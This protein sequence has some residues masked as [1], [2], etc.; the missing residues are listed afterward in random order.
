MNRRQFGELGETIAARALE[1]SGLRIVARNVRYPEGEIDIVAED[2]DTL[3]FVEVR[4]RRG[5]A[6]GTPEE[7]VTPR[8]R[9]RLV[10]AAHRFLDEHG[11]AETDWRI[12]LIAVEL[13]HDGR[14]LRVEHFRSVVEG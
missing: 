11:R 13:A 9:A 7:S 10:S 14:L 8:K 3:V 1:R 4:S 6:F 5:A 12:D 2:G